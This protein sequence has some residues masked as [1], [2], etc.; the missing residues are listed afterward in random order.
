MLWR[1]QWLNWLLSPKLQAITCDFHFVNT[2]LVNTRYEL[3]FT[4]VQW[5]YNL[6]LNGWKWASQSSWQLLMSNIGSSYFVTCYFIHLL[7]WIACSTKIISF[8]NMLKFSK[9]LFWWWKVK[10]LLRYLKIFFICGSEIF[11]N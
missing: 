10:H 7:S 11:K 6:W 2:P 1:S 3:G 9:S 5:Y 8:L 4:L